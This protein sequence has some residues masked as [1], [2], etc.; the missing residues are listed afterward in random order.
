M[1]GEFQIHGGEFLNPQTQRKLDELSARSRAR[2]EKRNIHLRH[3]PEVRV[4]ARA[5]FRD[6]NGIVT[7]PAILV[8]V[9]SARAKASGT[10]DLISK[11]ITLRGT[12][13]IHASLSGAVGGAKSLFLLPLDLFFKKGSAGAVVPVE[14]SGTYS[15]PRFKASLRRKHSHQRRAS[16]EVALWALLV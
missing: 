2:R 5:S 10:F 12:V 15:H 14:V 13:A 11:A 16:G 9:P 3:P 8:E 4:E 1:M 6:R 7:F